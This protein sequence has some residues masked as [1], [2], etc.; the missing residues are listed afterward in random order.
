MQRIY[1]D[2]GGFRDVVAGEFTY[3]PSH[4][5]IHFDGYAI[6]NL[7]E[8]GSGGEVGDIVATGGK[9]SFCLIDIA[10]YDANSGPSNYG[11]CGTIQGVT[12]GW[13]DVYNRN[14]PDQWINIAGV[15]DG[16]YYL[17]V[18]T[19]P[20]NQLLE[21]DET[22]NTTIITVTIDNGPGDT[23]DRLEPNDSFESATNLGMVSHRVE[24]GLSIHTADDV[25]YFQ[26]S[27]PESGDFEIYVNFSHD[28][29]NLD[30]FLYDDSYNLLMSGDS[31]DDLEEFQFEVL[32]GET[33]FLEVI[34]NSGES[35]AYDLEF[36][37][38]GD[39]ISETVMSSDVPVD[40][41]DSTSTGSPGVV[42]TSTLEG[43]DINITDL[44]AI[45]ADLEH[46]YLADLHFELTSPA[47]TTAILI[48]STQESPAGPLG[49]GDDFFNTILD[50]QAPTVIDD[51]TA[52]Y[53]GSYNVNFG[54]ISNP[55]SVFNGENALGTW[56]VSISDWF[57]ADTGTLNSWG[58]MFTGID[59]QPGDFLEE[60]DAFPQATDLGI[61]GEA[62]FGNLSIHSDTD[63]DFFRFN[64]QETT[65]AEIELMFDHSQ[66]NL[67]F[68]VY[69][70]FLQEVAPG[71]VDHGQR[72]LDPA[73]DRHGPVLH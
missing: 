13:S 29:G 50:D 45:F 22:N 9:I 63:V 43:P 49:G 44:N 35:N 6:Y 1:D 48:R 72:V 27:S 12:A 16:D 15:A 51:G 11:S 73:G 61:V 70:S 25:D 33:F 55:F 53:T 46:S 28:L 47:G 2:E 42:A 19:D 71:R 62:S 20:E 56:T 18:V 65:D 41:P 58:L 32:A 5:H 39:V 3:H 69:D 68:V 38:P 23:G 31:I 40:I 60:N 14:L 34:G 8:I 52:P 37:G 54:D 67:D 4:G 36:Y 57:A 7:R 21:S 24:A 10:R 66:G 59:G 30:A 26:F 17:E 64:A